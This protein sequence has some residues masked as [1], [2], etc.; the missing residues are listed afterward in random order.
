MKLLVLS[1]SHAGLQFMRHCV[2]KLKPDGIIHLG[3]YYADADVLREEN[4]RLPF[5]QVPGNCDRYRCPFG[6][7]EVV[8]CSF[9]GVVFF[10]TH[11]HNHHVKMGL[12]ALLNDARRSGAAVVLYGHTH[13]AD[14]HQEEDGL[15]VMN[16]GAAGSWSGSVGVIEIADKKVSACAI[17]TQADI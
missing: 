6:A 13:R 7:P 17:L 9:G 10:I 8:K 3:D 4:P 5:V 14:C 2:A 12:G 11:G 1:D 16:P 15:W